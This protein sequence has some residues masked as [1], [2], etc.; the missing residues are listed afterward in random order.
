MMAEQAEPSREALDAADALRCPVALPTSVQLND[1]YRDGWNAA[2]AAQPRVK[3]R[4]HP[5]TGDTHIIDT[6]T[7]RIVG[8]RK[9]APP[10]PGHA[11]RLESIRKYMVAYEKHCGHDLDG[12][13]TEASSTEGDGLMERPF[14]ANERRAF[15]A[16]LVAKEKSA[17][18]SELQPRTSALRFSHALWVSGTALLLRLLGATQS[19]LAQEKQNHALTCKMHAVTISEYEKLKSALAESRAEVERLKE[20]IK[21]DIEQAL[22]A[23]RAQGV[24]EG[25][26][27]YQP[28]VA[29]AQAVLAQYEPHEIVDAE[30]ALR[31]ALS[32]VAA[33]ET[34]E[35]KDG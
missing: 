16:D 18:V 10:Q 8:A 26:E 20:Q 30:A 32:A 22:A 13:G 1:A 4:V 7:G 24:R 3:E 6:N 23:A 11:E 5:L 35:E 9:T 28:L 29:A 19:A 31:D 27:R 21:H 15:F 17:H 14:S 12:G 25:A 34:Q 33:P 2:L